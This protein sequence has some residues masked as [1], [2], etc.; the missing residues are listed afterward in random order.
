MLAFTILMVCFLKRRRRAKVAHAKL[1][2]ERSLM[3]A[4]NSGGKS[5][6]LFS[7]HEM[8]RATNNFARDR[9]LGCGGFGEV[10][11]GELDD[12]TVVA[13]KSAKIGNIKGIDQ[14]LNEVR[15]LSQVNHRSL[16][17]L[18]GC[19]VESDLPLMVYEYVPNGNLYDHLQD[20]SNTLDWRT[21][22][23]IAVQSAEGLAYLHSAAY[24]PIYHRD[25]KSSNILLDKSMNARVADFGLSRLAEPD[26]T[27]VSTCAQGT[28]GYLDPEY[29]RNY[30]L[31]DKS[32]VY[33]FGVV[34][35][36]LVTSQKAIDFFRGQDDVNLAVMVQI[37]KEEGRM[38]EVLDMQLVKGASKEVIN[39]MRSVLNLALECLQE[40]RLNRPSMKEAA[41]TLQQIMHSLDAVGGIDLKKSSDY[42]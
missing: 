26:M 10:Y 34:L 16:V 22:L 25:V 21:R 15:V 20:K 32:D 38:D 37:R 17:R 33:S 28:L 39:S 8:K 27:H 13:I 1:V 41:E 5:A 24:P 36:E 42:P 6:R 35:L 40:N 3:L 23:R 2:K 19:C 4:N 31:T 14:V 9:V 29:Y 18:L 11:K 7:K 30:Q 12:K